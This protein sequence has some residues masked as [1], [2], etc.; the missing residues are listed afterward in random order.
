MPPTLQLRDLE[1]ASRLSH[2]YRITTASIEA[3]VYGIAIST[4]RKRLKR[5]A[6]DRWVCPLT[7]WCSDVEPIDTPLFA[8][9]PGDPEPNYGAVSY[10]ARSRWD[11]KPVRKTTVYTASTKMLALFGLPKRPHVKLHQA[12]H[13]LGCNRMYWFARR[14]WPH[15]NFIGE[16][17]FAP[18]GHGVG[19][20]D[21]QLCD[22]ERIVYVLEH[23]GAYRMDRVRHLHEHVAVERSLPYFLF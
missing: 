9:A 14:T 19:V 2:N 23:A 3:D 10:L 13:D 6:E 18:R 8:W 21:A 4:M 17:L 1:I 7:A 22:G 15:L 5:L 11:E 20:E 16:D 12:T